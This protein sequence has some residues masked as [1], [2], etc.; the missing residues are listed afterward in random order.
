MVGSG[1]LGAVWA[2]FYRREAG[3]L[4]SADRRRR[5]F[6]R[7]ILPVLGQRHIAD[8]KRSEIVRLLDDI[9]D[10]S[11]ARTARMV[12]LYLSRLFNWHASRTEEFR[13][14]IVR[15]MARIKP[16]NVQGIE[17]FRTTSFANCGPQSCALSRAPSVKP[18]S[19]LRPSGVAPISTRIHC[20]SSSSRACT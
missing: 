17:S 16:P 2:E 9:E 7:L 6:D 1:T 4:R 14:P 18:I 3:S 5:M 13:S 8:I 20:F 19:S 11:G 10:A 12:L 15:G